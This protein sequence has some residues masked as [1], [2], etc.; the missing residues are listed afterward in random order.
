MG[1]RKDAENEINSSSMADIAFLLLIFF[2]V[3][4]KI[5]TEKGIPVKLPPWTEDEPITAEIGDKNA[6]VVLV[7]SRDELL[8]EKEPINIKQLKDKAKKFIDNKGRN[9]ELSD[10]P[11]KAVISFKGNRG[12]SYEMYLAVYNELRAAYNELR[13]EYAMKT[14]GKPVKEFTEADSTKWEDVKRQY[15]LRLSE[16]EPVSF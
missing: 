8:V 13:D 7:N 1:K 11:Q 15:P 12:T 6:F 16:A 10:S 4:T 2:L 5:D 14:Y 9:P 3:V